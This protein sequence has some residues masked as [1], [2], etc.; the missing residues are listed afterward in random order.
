MGPTAAP[1]RTMT[2][3]FALHRGLHLPQ[4]H[5]PQFQLHRHLLTASG[6]VGQLQDL[7][8]KPAVVGRRGILEQ[9]QSRHRMEGS[10]A[11]EA[12]SRTGIATQILVRLQLTA[13]GAVGHVRDHVLKR[14]VVGHRGI[15]EQSWLRH[16]MEGSHVK[17]ATW[18]TEIATCILVHFG[19]GAE[20][21]ALMT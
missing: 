10:N 5:L 18:R 13:N 4:L 2:S 3:V 11:R 9:L 1:A 14:A 12:T 19:A 6:E 21:M 17:E 16:N 8:L 20:V 15:L 7:V